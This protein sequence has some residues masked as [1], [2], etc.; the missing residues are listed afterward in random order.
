MRGTELPEDLVLFKGH[1][2]HYALQPAK[3]LIKNGTHML[4]RDADGTDNSPELV[5]RITEFLEESGTF[6]SK[7]D[8]LNYYANNARIAQSRMGGQIAS[9]VANSN[10]GM[11]EKITAL[12]SCS[13]KRATAN[14]SR[15]SVMW[16]GTI[17]P[18]GTVQIVGHETEIP[19]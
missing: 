13:E 19:A 9:G 10:H 1:G 7:R 5:Q 15:K 17:V 14:L 11:A 16:S 2:D 8:W 18:L 3:E 12:L 6:M 4:L